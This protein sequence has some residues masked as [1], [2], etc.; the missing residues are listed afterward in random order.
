MNKIKT[1]ALVLKGFRYSESSKI[2]TLFTRSCGKF[3]ALIK[4]VRRQNSKL[5]GAFE[6]FNLIEIIYDKNQKKELQKIFLAE[7]INEFSALKN[8]LGKLA[9]GYKILDYINSFNEEFDTNTELFD[10]T[11]KI[12]ELINSNCKMETEDVNILFLE[13]LSNYLGFH[14]SNSK[15]YF[16]TFNINFAFNINE[17]Y[18]SNFNYAVEKK[19]EYILKDELSKKQLIEIMENEIVCNLGIAK[20]LI[21]SKI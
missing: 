21:T 13:K 2:V 20:K 14:F 10:F 19:S 17:V 8:D 18:N 15:N 16:E 11:V 5:S 3:S 1:R 4:G 6:T 12:L 9:L 7:C